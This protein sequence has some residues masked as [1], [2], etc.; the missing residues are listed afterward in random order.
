MGVAG[1]IDKVP[2]SGNG[3]LSSNQFFYHP[4]KPPYK[5]LYV[6]NNITHKVLYIL[7]ICSIRF[8]NSSMHICSKSIDITFPVFKKFLHRFFNYHY[9]PGVYTFKYIHYEE[10]TT[11]NIIL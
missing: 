7:G 3:A 11:Y 6:K 8:S 4:Y 10:K 2:K 9:K 5:Y 1:V